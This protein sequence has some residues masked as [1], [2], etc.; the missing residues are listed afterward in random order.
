MKNFW[1]KI[2]HKKSCAGICAVVLTIVVIGVLPTLTVNILAQDAGV[3]DIMPLVDFDDWVSQGEVA[4][5]TS[6]AGNSRPDGETF[7]AMNN[8]G[9]V[10]VK[11]RGAG[12]KYLVNS[13][14]EFAYRTNE[15]PGTLG[16]AKVLDDGEQ[17]VLSFEVYSGVENKINADV[18]MNN[19]KGP[20]KLFALNQGSLFVYDAMPEHI[21]NNVAVTKGSVIGEYTL[22]K[23]QWVK[24]D[25]VYTRGGASPDENANDSL[26]VYIN[27]RSVRLTSTSELIIS[28][29]TIP[30]CNSVTD[31]T[32]G[33][34]TFG[35]GVID[36]LKATHYVDGAK[37]N[38]QNAVIA[39]TIVPLIDFDNY[40]TAVMPVTKA[41]AGSAVA[42]TEITQ[43]SS[44]QPLFEVQNDCNM[45]G[46][47]YAEIAAKDGAET[48]KYFNQA[49]NMYMENGEEKKHQNIALNYNQSQNNALSSVAL[50]EGEQLCYSLSVH[51]GKS[52]RLYKRTGADADTPGILNYLFILNNGKFYVFDGTNNDANISSAMGYLTL[53]Q[54]QWVDIKVIYT[55]GDGIDN[56]ILTGGTDD[57][58]EILIGPDLQTLTPVSGYSG[59]GRVSDDGSN[60]L[61]V[62]YNG[63]S[64]SRFTFAAF[65]TFDNFSVI[66]YGEADKTNENEEVGILGIDHQPNDFTYFHSKRIMSSS[67]D[68]EF[69]KLSATSGNSYTIEPA[70][71]KN[72]YKG[73]RLIL[74][75]SSG[76]EMPSSYVKIDM[77][78]Y[79]V[80][81]D[82]IP[83]DRE[84]R[85]FLIE[86]KFHITSA[87]MGGEIISLYD[88]EWTDSIG[89]HA[90]V[91]L[92]DGKL[93]IG[94]KSR[95]LSIK[96]EEGNDKWYHLRMIFNLDNETYDAILDGELI[97]QNGEIYPEIQKLSK[98]STVLN[99]GN[100]ELQIREMEVTGLAKEPTLKAPQTVGEKY[101]FNITK[102]SQFIDDN[103][104]RT[105]LADKVVFHGDG[106][107]IYNMGTKTEYEKGSFIYTD[108]IR[109][110]YVPLD[111]INSNLD[112]SVAY[113]NSK[114]TNDGAELGVS[115]LPKYV[116]GTVLAPVK[117]ITMALGYDSEYYKYGN[118]VIVAERGSILPE[119]DDVDA[120]PW[121]D[122]NFYATGWNSFYQTYLTDTQEISNF[123]FYDRPTAAQLEETFKSKEQARPRVIL[124]PEKVATIKERIAADKATNAY[125]GVYAEA[126]AKI[127]S[128][129]KSQLNS[130]YIAE[131]KFNENDE[132]RTLSA[133]NN[134]TNY[135]QAI[136]LAYQLSSDEEL[137]ERCAQAGVANM[138]IISTFPDFNYCHV[139]DAGVWLQGC[140]VGF[141]W[142]YNEMTEEERE[143]I[144]EGILNIGIRPMNRTYYAC[145]P[146][147]L[148]RTNS[149]MG[150]MGSANHYVKWK[151]NFIPYTQYG[152][153][154]ASLAF[155]EYDNEVCF[156]TLEKAIRNWEYCNLGIY[157]A[158]GWLEGKGYLG[159]VHNDTAIA[160]ASV[161]NVMGDEYG[162]LDAKGFEE[163]FDAAIHLSSLS[164]SFNFSDES[165]AGGNVLSIPNSTSFYA[166]YY[167]REDLHRVRQWR[168]RVGDKSTW[169]ILDLAYYNHFDDQT[170]VTDREKVF[171][172]LATINYTE[173][174]EIVTIH[175]DWVNYNSLFFGIAGGP[176]R[177]Y[178]F[179]TDGGDFSLVMNGNRWTYEMGTGNYNIGTNFTKYAGRAEGHNTLVIKPDE[180]PF[181]IQGLTNYAWTAQKEQSVAKIM[182]YGETVDG[183]YAILDMS[184]LYEDFGAQRVHR[185]ALIDD[186]YETVTIRDEIV[187]PEDE[188]FDG[189]WFM[190]TKADYEII[191]ENTIKLSMHNHKSLEEHKKQT[192]I[193]DKDGDGDVDDDDYEIWYNNVA[194]HL[195]VQVHVDGADSYELKMMPAEPLPSSPVVS[196]DPTNTD[197]VNKVAIYYK[198]SGEI[199]ITVRMSE[200]LAEELNT[201]PIAQWTFPDI[202]ALEDG[203]RCMISARYTEE[204][205][206]IATQYKGGEISGAQIADAYCGGPNK[207][208]KCSVNSIPDGTEECVLYLWEKNTM[209]PLAKPIRVRMS[210]LA[211]IE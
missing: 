107:L 47:I 30:L 191:D 121:I 10:D 40:E 126:I 35:K 183:A 209:Q 55:A 102:T 19:D 64:A 22:P 152:M 3:I 111:V 86:G 203:F 32:I 51:S 11:F 103:L 36:N 129:A 15:N 158:G 150:N 171:K 7:Y 20:T 69:A 133:A 91:N 113:S 202:I 88:E 57:T 206:L 33:R 29:R 74:T 144:A 159:V 120:E 78:T 187:F 12:D 123:V 174:T 105:Y 127:E 24:I 45:T 82:Y 163:S 50:K 136:G 99:Q 178:H 85:Y 182:D 93:V 164:G 117:E 138:K 184:T 149:R 186:D 112:E 9:A 151:S 134:F 145:L 181:L 185:G 81:T 118:M 172:D 26:D 110:V 16:R 198:G 208:Y 72:Q 70:D 13:I 170:N 147:A 153:V 67:R 53:P 108:D 180:D 28:G 156:D 142:F 196:N 207:Q 122:G 130:G 101:D 60:K 79:N 188:E 193:T 115:S 8:P 165:G 76:I 34:F 52:F 97:C 25:L 189:W 80:I 38:S 21:E 190:H 2:L 205:Q 125:A 146:S 4:A 56:N 46:T 161:L 204:Y 96:D 87:D 139:I 23:K 194:K 61:A 162:V 160:F 168:Y 6:Y 54:N 166:D 68:Y 124:N 59:N 192:K 128:N 104:T 48:D 201:T 116:G 173:G 83:K 63:A 31:G 119:S 179:H 18:R 137:R 43:W 27:G 73:D 39:T 41:A 210:D 65:S 109:D 169:S 1:L 17:M 140:A 100:G 71:K 95:T 114:W 131:Y 135:M 42:K 49:Y 175:E 177:H 44:G 211:I 200:T 154:T 5:N 155:A 197:G 62:D 141:D 58:V 167:G 195:Y 157:P 77:P 132:A 66:K 84:F 143:Q 75:R 89:K 199:N 37:F 98:V 90:V 176:T 14:G 92:I 94:D 106:S 148:S